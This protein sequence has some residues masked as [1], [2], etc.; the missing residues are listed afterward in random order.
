M[1]FF[2]ILKILQKWRAYIT[3]H[4]VVNHCRG[5]SES[6][7]RQRDIFDFFVHLLFRELYFAQKLSELFLSSMSANSTMKYIKKIV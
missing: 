1:M 4:M 2:G 5:R 3:L 6:S 7:F